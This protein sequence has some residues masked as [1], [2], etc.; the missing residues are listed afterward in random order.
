[1]TSHGGFFD[2]LRPICGNGNPIEGREEV[3]WAAAV[4]GTSKNNVRT[5]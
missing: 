4:S 2:G 1:L 5:T 3:F